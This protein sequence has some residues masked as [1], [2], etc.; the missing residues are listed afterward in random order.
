M[1]DKIRCKWCNLNNPVYVKYHDE[2]WGVLNSDDGYLFEMLIL[3]SFQAGLSWEIVLNKRENFRSAYDNFDVLKV[4][5][6]G[7]DKISA[8]IQDVSI[9][10]NKRKILASIQNARVFIGIQKQF[11]SFY[12]YLC[13][14][15]GGKTVFET[16]KT[17]SSLSDA[18]S[19]DLNIRGMKFIGTTVI[20]S[21]LQAI[22]I[23][24]SHE[25]QCFKHKNP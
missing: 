7:E 16:D 12:R 18:I 9:I 14:F 15:T 25:K 13:T 20:Y 5:K 19:K 4:S 21:Y 3:E 1:Q 10:R 22:G 17:Y 23:I 2:E 24:N 11:G 6:Y 8:L